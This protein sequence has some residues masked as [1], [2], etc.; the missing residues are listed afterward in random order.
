MHKATPFAAEIQENAKSD[1]VC[2]TEAQNPFTSH[3]DCYPRQLH[4]G[5]DKQK[6]KQDAGDLEPNDFRPKLFTEIESTLKHT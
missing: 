4:L 1:T 2:C 6:Y 5:W 3:T